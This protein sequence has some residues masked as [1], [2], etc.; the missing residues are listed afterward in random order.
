MI[1][2]IKANKSIRD[3]P[4]LSEGAMMGGEWPKLEILDNFEVIVLRETDTVSKIF[5]LIQY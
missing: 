3:L 4:T 2:F 5:P 1:Q